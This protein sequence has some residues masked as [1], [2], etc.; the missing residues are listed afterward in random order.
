MGLSAGALACSYCFGGCQSNDQVVTP[1]VVDFTLDLTDPANGA[2]KTNGGYLYKEGVIVARTLGGDYI[3]VSATCT[4]AG[5]TVEYVASG[6]RFYCPIHK[7]NFGTTGA[8][9]NGPATHPLGTYKI[10]LNNTSLRVYT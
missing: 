8:V 5:G 9:I 7:S 6:N 3:A 2:L 4:H 1:P 10:S